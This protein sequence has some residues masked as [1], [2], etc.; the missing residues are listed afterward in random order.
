M[1]TDSE[2]GK[3]V[4]KFLIQ[5]DVETPM[6]INKTKDEDKIFA[7]SGAFEIIMDQ[8]GLDQSDDSL[9]DTPRRVAEMYIYQFFKGL[10]YNNFPKCTTV[11]NK[12]HYDEMVSVD[13]INVQSV[14]EHHFVQID[15][16]AKV[17][18]I[19]NEKV[20]GL[21]KLNRI[22]DFF[23]RRPQVQERLTEQIFWA[24][25]YVLQTKDIAVLIKA[26]HYCVKAR[27]IQDV[28]STTTTSKLGG[29]FKNEPEARH[30]FLNL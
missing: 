29:V 25:S 11:E 7:I 13:R 27:G 3:K 4:Q 18:Y 14:C 17:A 22:V 20:V 23:S 8:L 24:L 28:N 16:E 9:S 6:V 10:D 19:P 12:M 15:G 5:K 2:L 30:E 26:T 21:S 1:K